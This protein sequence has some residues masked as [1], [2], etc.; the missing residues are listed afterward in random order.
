MYFG[1]SPD[2]LNVDFLEPSK[3]SCENFAQKN[4]QQILSMR[5]KWVKTGNMIRKIK[6]KY[7]YSSLYVKVRKQKIAQS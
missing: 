7:E 5:K 2:I 6:K 3:F 4:G 1:L